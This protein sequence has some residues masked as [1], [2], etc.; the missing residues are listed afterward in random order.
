MKSAGWPLLLCILAS[1]GS[2]G[3]ADLGRLF[4]TPA[5]RATLDSARRQN[6]RVDVGNE[7]EQSAAPVPQHISVTGLVQRSDGKST[8]W[9]NNRAVNEQQQT[10]G[11]I[12]VTADRKEQRV[13]LSVPE[14]GRS[15]DLKVGQTVE[16]LSGTIAEGYSRQTPL[17]AL[18]KPGPVPEPATARGE[19]VGPRAPVRTDEA[20]A[21]AGASPQAGSIPLRR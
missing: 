2:A 8:V 14:S 9:L 10:G 21:P 3:A 13:K 11:G 15:V 6:I 18:E 16:V 4:F 12:V 17:K 1:A 5:Q 19:I 7:T 20:Q